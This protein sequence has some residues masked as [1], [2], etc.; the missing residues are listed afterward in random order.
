MI[1]IYALW[2]EESSMVYIGQST[3]ITSRYRGHLNS[4]LNKRHSN[5]RVQE[6]YEK[7]GEPE[8]VV[9]ETSSTKDL[10]ILEECW[11]EEFDSINKGLNIVKAGKA[12]YGVDS[13]ASKYSK[14]TILRIFILLYKYKMYPKVIASKLGISKST[15][16]D[17]R[18]G[19][20]HKWLKTHYPQ[21]FIS[22]SSENTCIGAETEFIDPTGKAVIIANINNFAKTHSPSNYK[23]FAR[24][25]S[26]VRSGK[27]YSSYGWKL[28]HRKLQINEVS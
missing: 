11:T 17:I 25:L 8:L 12:N 4:L 2:F 16:Y 28:S 20:T 14:I 22:I 19:R 26:Y 3:N 18:A 23:S 13:P 1:G 21:E 24:G 27:R 5:Y 10:N 7:Y 9:L 15:I 6:A